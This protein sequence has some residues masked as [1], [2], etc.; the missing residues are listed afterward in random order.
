MRRGHYA[1]EAEMICVGQASHLR[2]HVVDEEAHAIQADP[3]FF[4]PLAPL[5]LLHLKI[6]VER[7][8]GDGTLQVGQTQAG[9]VRWQPGGLV[10]LLAQAP[11]RGH[12]GPLCCGVCGPPL[13]QPGLLFSC[14]VGCGPRYSPVVGSSRFRLTRMASQSASCLLWLCGGKRVRQCRS[15]ERSGNLRT[16]TCCSFPSPTKAIRVRGPRASL[17][18]GPCTHQGSPHKPLRTFFVFML[19]CAAKL[20]TGGH[21]KQ[22]RWMDERARGCATCPA[23]CNT[24]FSQMSKCSVGAVLIAYCK[25]TAACAVYMT[26]WLPKEICFFFGFSFSWPAL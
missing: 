6:F 22:V 19:T 14:S 23:S 10:R 5:R 9:R 26:P 8:A 13:R 15:K 24:R 1:Q 11:P 21:T 7:V 2:A 17:R 25:Q 4:L 20:P 18:G 16:Q 12:C 3:H